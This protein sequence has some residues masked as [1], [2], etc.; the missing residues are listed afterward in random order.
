VEKA[1]NCGN[2][3]Q[4]EDDE[5]KCGFCDVSGHEVENCRK[6]YPEKRGSRKDEPMKHVSAKVAREIGFRLKHIKNLFRLLPRRLSSKPCNLDTVTHVGSINVSVVEPN[7]LLHFGTNIL[8]TT[9]A[10][11]PSYSLLLYKSTL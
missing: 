9:L 2:R 10:K 4:E 1:V 7:D 11:Q 5:P 6:T 3:E 8:P